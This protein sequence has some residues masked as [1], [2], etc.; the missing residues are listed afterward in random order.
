MAQVIQF[1]AF[2]EFRTVR[3]QWEEARAHIIGWR[4]AQAATTAPVHLIAE[5]TS[6][7]KRRKIGFPVS[8]LSQRE[9]QR[10]LATLGKR[11]SDEAVKEICSSL[12][13]RYF[14]HDHETYILDSELR[15]H[16][17]PADAWQLR[18][19]FL[20]LKGDNEGALAFLN[21][22]GRWSPV[23]GYVDMA[24]IVALQQAVKD[25]LT[26]PAERW[27]RGGYASPP[28]VNSRSSEF[29]YFVI[30]T[31]ACEAAIRTTTTADLLRQLRFKTCA[32]PDCG[33]PFPITS[34]HERNYCKQY[35]A[36]LESVRRGRKSTTQRSA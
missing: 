15:K 22:W 31:D 23:R 3:I 14:I 10:C 32:R 33:M 7:G 25:A 29:P 16:S 5:I 6:A 9:R 8:R 17:H 28:R 11:H 4:N 30:L 35:C 18:D 13:L 1:Q 34:R 20:R 21:K 26:S 12:E 36:H 27:F 19:D 2:F 24:E